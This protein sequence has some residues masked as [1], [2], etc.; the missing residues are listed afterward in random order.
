MMAQKFPSTLIDALMAGEV[1]FLCGT[2]VSARLLPD[3]KSLV[4]RTYQ[5]VGVE[6]DISE[7]RS[8]NGQRF[9]EVLGALGRRLADPD[10][11]VRTASELLAVPADPR[12]DQHR[13]VLRLSRDLNNR[14]LTV[15]TNFDTLLERALAQSAA[16]V[17]PQS[18]AGQSLP[19][20][21][22]AGFAGI[23]R[24]VDPALDLDGTPL[25]LTSA[26]YGDA[27]RRGC[28]LCVSDES[29]GLPESFDVSKSDTLGLQ[30]VRD[31][32]EQLRG[33]LRMDRTRGAS[34]AVTFEATDP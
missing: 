6:M 16:E 11:M 19:A 32:S 25:V 27:Y 34:F 10:A 13:T 23:I 30:L 5:R 7:R 17:R 31:L 21:G 2:G 18:F 26:D 12:L 29:V 15:T 9:E 28:G 33:D 4:D 24:L 3:F 14:V 20:P 22:G 1:V 8:Y